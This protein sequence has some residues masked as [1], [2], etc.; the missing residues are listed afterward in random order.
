[1]STA[2]STAPSTAAAI[3]S[4]DALNRPPR[5]VNL[6]PDVSINYQLNRWLS[7]MTPQALSDV[8]EVAARVSTYEEFTGEFLALGD[9]LLAQG[10]QRDGAFCLRAAEFFMPAEDK[11][12]TPTRTRFL[13]L[14]REVYGISPDQYASAPTSTT[15]CPMPAVRYPPCGWAGPT[16]APW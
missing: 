13:E 1:M 3:A 15:P 4:V 2:P 5:F 14:V 16:G 9:K 11:R 10:R 8:A 12:K 7:A 6:H